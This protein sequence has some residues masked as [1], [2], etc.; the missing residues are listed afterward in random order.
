MPP[1]EIEDDGLE[2]PIVGAWAEEKYRIIGMYDRLFS[3]GMKNKWGCRVYIDLYSG[4][5]HAKIKN[6]GKLISGSPLIA[7][8]VPDQFDKYIFCEKTAK[9]MNA[10]KQRV[11]TKF[12][13]ASVDFVPGD[14]NEQV[15]TILS[16]VPAHSKN[17][18]VL[19]LCVVDPFN[20]GI[21]F[22]TI[23]T[24]ASAKLMDFL[25]IL[26]VGMDATRN[27]AVYLDPDNHQIDDFLGDTTWREKWKLAQSKIPFR[28]FLAQEYANRMASLGY[29]AI[30]VD[31]M[32]EVKSDEKNL[33]L[34]HVA[35]FSKSKTGYAFWKDVLKY[36]DPQQSLL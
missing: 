29:L 24:L 12:P 23:K 35:F 21:K 4:A 28:H 19:S 36:S 5:G 22:E 16:Y 6:T 7:L 8:N 30:G 11:T 27:E 9:L 20:I 13:R 1:D 15:N 25:M 2:T 3:T 26:A 10:L 31:K 18:T 14:C 34:Y 33:A 32:K 17:K